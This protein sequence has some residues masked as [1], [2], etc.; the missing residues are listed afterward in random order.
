MVSK[1]GSGAVSAFVS[2]KASTTNDKNFSCSP[3]RWGDYGGATPDPA[4]SLVAATGT[5]W[6]TNQWTPVAALP[7]AAT[8]PGTGRP[9]RKTVAAHP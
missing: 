3:C 9:R 4:A 7:K 1:V 8:G 5:V 6:L 2:V